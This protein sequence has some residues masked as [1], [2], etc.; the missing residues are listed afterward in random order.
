MVPLEQIDILFALGVTI[1]DDVDFHVA[2]YIELSQELT[3]CFHVG[4]VSASLWQ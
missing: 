3:Y 1:Q 4:D 2:H